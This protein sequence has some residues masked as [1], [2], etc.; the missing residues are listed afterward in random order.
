MT[1]QHLIKL[2]GFTLASYLLSQGAMANSLLVK[3]DTLFDGTQILNG[4][5]AVLVKKAKLLK[6][7]HLPRSMPPAL[8]SLK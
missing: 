1:F 3:A 6:S 8:K 5:F 4:P 7:A 2:T